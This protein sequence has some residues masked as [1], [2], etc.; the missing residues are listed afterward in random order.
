LESDEE[1]ERVDYALD[2]KVCIKAGGC[3]SR[4]ALLAHF[5]RIAQGRCMGD[6]LLKLEMDNEATKRY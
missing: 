1:E 5:D 6:A 2:A 3:G 4:T